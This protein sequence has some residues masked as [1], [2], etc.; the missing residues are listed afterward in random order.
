MYT[1]IKFPFSGGG[2]GGLFA[3]NILALQNHHILAM[4]STNA[5]SNDN[6]RWGHK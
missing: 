4:Y 6:L 3:L 1:F 5:Y 2:G